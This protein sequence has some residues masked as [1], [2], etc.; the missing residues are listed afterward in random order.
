MSPNL[1]CLQLTFC[2]FLTI[3]LPINLLDLL[4]L[5]VSHMEEAATT[6][7]TV[8]AFAMSTKL[9]SA[10]AAII[11]H[12]DCHGHCC[13]FKG[14]PEPDFA[15][16]TLCC[17]QQVA[18]YV[19]T[20]VIGIHDPPPHPLLL[21]TAPTPAPST[22]HLLWLPTNP[23]SSQSPS[24]FSS[25]SMKR[26]YSPFFLPV[27]H[28]TIHRRRRPLIIPF[29][30]MG[31]T[32]YAHT[33]CLAPLP[34]FLYKKAYLAQNLLGLDEISYTMHLGSLTYFF[35]SPYNFFLFFFDTTH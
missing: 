21:A 6:T 27:I 29:L 5:E 1:Q 18:N 33:H 26:N 12:G 15:P 7:V 9:S 19:V 10:P 34:L 22:R 2:L 24:P 17:H 30:F 8:E 31:R 35:F 4:V 11:Q 25:Q 14:V 13:C 23:A 32:A 20:Q 28:Q 16:A 3:C